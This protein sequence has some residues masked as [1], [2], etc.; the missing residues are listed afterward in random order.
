MP[1]EFITN[2]HKKRKKPRPRDF[3]DDDVVEVAELTV[4][5]STMMTAVIY[6]VSLV[7]VSEKSMKIQKN[8]VNL[9][10]FF[11]NRSAF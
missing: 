10:V 4:F 11:K 8:I 9:I 6:S 7:G 1:E 5:R 3:D 2:V